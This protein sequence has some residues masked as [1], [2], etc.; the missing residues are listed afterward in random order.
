MSYTAY[1]FRVFKNATN[2]QCISV[3]DVLAW[4]REV[5]PEHCLVIEHDA[6]ADDSRPHWHALLFATGN[7]QALRVSLT[8]RVPSVKANYSLKEMPTDAVQAYT[9]YMCHSSGRGDEVKL[10]YA[11]LAQYTQSFLQSQN[12][13][14]WDARA[15]FKKDKGGKKAD[16]LL[17]TCIEHARTH[18]LNTINQV[19]DLVIEEHMARKMTLYPVH[20][21]ARVFTVWHAI[22]DTRARRELRE[23]IMGS[24]I[25]FSPIVTTT[26]YLEWPTNANAL[27]DPLDAV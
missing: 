5:S 10:V 6:D 14:F 12:V 22:G 7:A 26:S 16:D 4:L 2:G 17:S 21:K 1:K 20:V 9:R 15:A 23:E 25:Y 13:A 27:P 8:R 11:S 18:K 19:A 24:G 3:D